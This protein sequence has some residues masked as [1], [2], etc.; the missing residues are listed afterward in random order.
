[1]N[2]M[3]DQAQETA[4]NDWENPQIVGRNKEPGHVPLG[5]YADVQTALAGEPQASPNILSLNGDWKFQWSPNPASAP[6]GFYEAGYDLSEWDSLSVP[7]NWQVQESRQGVRYGQPMYTN[8]QY[9]FPPDDLPRVPEDDNPV[10]S[11]QRAF[12]LPAEWAGRRTHLLFEGVDSAFYLW[13]NGQSVGYSQGSRLPAEFD[14][15]SYLQEGENCVALRVYRW[16]DGSYLEDQDFWRLSGIYRDVSLIGLPQE[17]IQDYWVQTALD[18]DYDDAT[19]KVKAKII[20]AAPADSGQ[21]CLQVSL[22][23]AEGK[24]VWDAPLT[25]ELDRGLR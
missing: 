15:T 23:D 24:A 6:G 5:I 7:G 20:D 19:L 18:D 8:V 12:T 17:Y 10:G 25:Q 9:P 13:V 21:H 22:W 2:T 16:S 11:Y 14:V 1:M 3:P 4:A